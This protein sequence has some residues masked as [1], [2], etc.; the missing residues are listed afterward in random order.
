MAVSLPSDLIADVIR[1]ADPARRQAAAQRLQS[2]GDGESVFAAMIEQSAPLDAG[3]VLQEMP[4]ASEH[5]VSGARHGATV[6]QTGVF[7]S[8]EQV[9]LRNLFETLLPES[10]SG[11]FGGGPSAG[12]WRSMAADQLAGIYAENGGIGVANMLASQTSSSTPGREDQW[13]YFRLQPLK[14]LGGEG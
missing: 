4:L 11:A 7:R 10:A 1:N 6:E 2:F 12:V 9:V 8:F 3:Q 14:A 13:P 5:R